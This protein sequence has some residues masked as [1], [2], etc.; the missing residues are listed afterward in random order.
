MVFEKRGRRFQM[1]PFCDKDSKKFFRKINYF[2]LK[3]GERF[4]VKI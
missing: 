1:L 2:F 3:N 4:S